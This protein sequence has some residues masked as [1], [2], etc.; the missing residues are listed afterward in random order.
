MT[1]GMGAMRDDALRV[2]SE[3]ES[4]GFEVPVFGGRQMTLHV[5][6]QIY[7]DRVD[8]ESLGEAVL[9]LAAA[10]H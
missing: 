3:L 9:K 4:V 2:R 5:C 6:A 8:I 1:R 10:R 7:C